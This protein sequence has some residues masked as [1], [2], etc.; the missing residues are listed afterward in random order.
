ME[1]C[2]HNVDL[3]YHHART[4]CSYHRI[5]LVSNQ[6][7]TAF[8]SQNISNIRHLWGHGGVRL[9]FRRAGAET[10]LQHNLIHDGESQ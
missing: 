10:H 2:T 8:L 3:T 9:P 4:L 5:W 7:I 1:E 6:N